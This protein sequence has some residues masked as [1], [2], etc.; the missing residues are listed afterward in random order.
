MGYAIDANG[1]TFGTIFGLIF[2]IVVAL[3]CGG[4]FWA[5]AN[6][7]TMFLNAILD[8]KSHYV[9]AVIILVFFLLV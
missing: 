8:T 5:I 6:T 3:F 2:Q 4:V 1:F 9:I 7:A